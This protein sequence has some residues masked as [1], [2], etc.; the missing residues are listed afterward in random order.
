MSQI[1]RLGDDTWVRAEDPS[2]V[3]AVRRPA[4]ELALAAGL[5]ADRTAQIAVAVTEAVSNL[6]KHAEQG[7][8]L[9]RLC[10]GAPD[11]VELI[12]LDR[13]PGMPDV[14]RALRDGYST[15]GTLGIGLGAIARIASRYDVHSL[16]GR[17]TVLA[18]QFGAAEL[19][20]PPPATGLVR[21]IGEEPVSGDSYAIVTNGPETTVLVCD[22]LGHGPAAAQASREAVALFLRAPGDE[23]KEILD[24][25][26]RGLRSTRGGAVAVARVSATTVSYAG[27]GNI[28]GWISYADARQGMISVPGIAGHAGGTLR[29]YEYEVGEHATVVLH[30]DGLTERWSAAAVP[31]LFARSPAVVAAGLLREAGS[32]RDDACVVIVRPRP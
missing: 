10:P 26:H 22:G 14:A 23:P 25:V 2:A 30:S 15:S 24:R 7:M 28:S 1:K 8:A 17:G 19:P 21:P 9:V 32:R 4:T 12:T 27:L 20:A 3:G 5:G 29:Q 13:G 11:V 31:G 18:V 16:P 6:V